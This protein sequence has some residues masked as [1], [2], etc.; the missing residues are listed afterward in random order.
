MKKNIPEILAEWFYRLPI[1][2]AIPPYSDVE[3]QVLEQVLTENGINS[4]PIIKSILNE[5]PADNQFIPGKTKLDVSTKAEPTKAEAEGNDDYNTAIKRRLQVDTIPIPNGRYTIEEPKEGTKGSF[6]LDVTDVKDKEIFELLWPE[7]DNLAIIGK[8]EIALYWLFHF[9]KGESKVEDTRAEGSGA[10]DLRI[11]GHAVEV[12]SYK[13]HSMITGLGRWSDY[14]EERR[15]VQ[16]IFGLHALTKAFSEGDTANPITEISFGKKHIIEAAESLFVFL[17]LPNLDQL[18]ETPPTGFGPDSV[19]SQ[20]I[21]HA[22]SI[23]GEM[24][25]SLTDS[26]VTGTTELNKSSK[27]ADVAV[28]VL[29]MLAAKKYG[30]KPGNMG[31]IANIIPGKADIHFHQVNIA[32]INADSTESLNVSGGSIKGNLMKIFG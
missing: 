2:Y 21:F 5:A 11:D 12:K 15:I 8:G 25:T 26:G 7:N 32:A 14:K 29:Q 20:M 19:F 1:G 23:F 9:Q 24:Q 30:D 16:N 27:P 13:S 28:Q 22:N 31:Y 17:N 3:I 4:T 6:K 10:P 18:T